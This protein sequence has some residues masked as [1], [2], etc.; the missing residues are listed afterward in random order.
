VVGGL[1][2][3]AAFQ[4]VGFH[5]GPVLVTVAG[6][7]DLLGGL[8]YLRLGWRGL[9]RRWFGLSRVGKRVVTSRAG[10]G[11]GAGDRHDV[12]GRRDVVAVATG[13]DLRDDLA[14]QWHRDFGDS[15]DQSVERLA[16][17]GLLEEFQSLASGASLVAAFEYVGFLVVADDLIHPVIRL[18]FNILRQ[19]MTANPGIYQGHFSPVPHPPACSG[20][21]GVR[22]CQ[23]S[24]HP[25]Q[26]DRR[27]GQ[28]PGCEGTDLGGESGN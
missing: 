10:F 21:P 22:S 1:L 26:I 3:T 20:K 7:A 4:P 17:E 11:F 24:G 14:D 18:V 23:K 13:E 27:Q 9:R 5:L 15:E 19:Q 12:R 16:P 2:H 6:I 25:R 8:G 28:I